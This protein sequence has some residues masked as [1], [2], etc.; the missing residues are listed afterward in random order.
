MQRRKHRMEIFQQKGVALEW[1]AELADHRSDEAAAHLKTR[2][3]PFKGRLGIAIP[4]NRVLM[5]IMEFPST[6]PEELLGMAELQIDKISPF[7]T[8]QMALAIEVL[9]QA[10]ESSRVLIAA[11]Q[12]DYIDHLGQFLTSAGLYPQSVDVDVL[13]W[14]Y[15]IRDA[16]KVPAEGQHILVIHDEGCAQLLIVRDGVPV[17]IRA[18]DA[19]LVMTSPSFAADIADEIE[20]TLMTMESAWGSHP[21]TGLSLWTNGAASEELIRALSDACRIEV[22]THDLASLPPLSEGCSRRMAAEAPAALDLAPVAW[23]RGIASR[24]YQRLAVT[25]AGTTF[26][27]WAL[28]M[29]GLWGWTLY[30][31]RLLTEAQADM[32]KLQRDVAA[33][34]ELKGQ[35]SSLEQYADRTFSGLECLREIS[36]KLPGNVDITSFL[37]NKGGEVNVRGEADN[38]Q[39]IN[40]FIASLEKSTLFKTVRTEGITTQVRDGRSRSQFRITMTLPAPPPQESQ[41]PGS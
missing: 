41:E 8:D 35:I 12:H 10:G 7:P 40:D 22:V 4:G 3:P 2:L 17:V 39:P 30:Q 25:I 37:Y 6:D 1:P 15:L 28:I 32:T 31:K 16:G 14:W 29:L 24:K 13:G 20:Y 26:G 19:G 5:R 18:L 38:D 21:T 36:E 23:K 34:R 33:V 27:V 9:S 11:V